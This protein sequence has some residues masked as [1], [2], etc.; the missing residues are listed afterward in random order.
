MRLDEKL[1]FVYDG[2]SI[3]FSPSSDY[4]WKDQDGM[5]GGSADIYTSQKSARPGAK[6]TGK[7]L[8]AKPITIFGQIRESVVDYAAARETLLRSVYAGR[9]GKLVYEC[10]S[11]TRYTPCIVQDAPDPNRGIFAGFEI[12]FFRASPFWREGD[13]DARRAT[14]IAVWMDNIEFPLEIPE[15]GLELTYQ[16]ASLLVNIVNTGDYEMP[17]T[18]VMRATSAVSN[19][20]LI[21]VLTQE[22]FYIDYD[23]EAG[24]VVTVETDD[25]LMTVTLLRDGV[26]TNIFNDVPE[27][28]TWFK[29]AVGDN[30]L[31]ADASDTDYVSFELFDDEA[32]YLGV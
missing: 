30:Y 21:N 19:P 28:A 11:Y 8:L 15:E 13:G 7:H 23:L 22:F 25:D 4:F 14:G 31:R 1:T 27:D 16:A 10:A 20:K 18:I 6:V 5:G 9:E 32:L 24:D 26:E 12:E 17:L 2:G 3:E 29:L